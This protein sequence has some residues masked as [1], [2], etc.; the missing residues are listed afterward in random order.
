MIFQLVISTNLS[1]YNVNFSLS[2][3]IFLNS[4]YQQACSIYKLIKAKQKQRKEEAK[5]KL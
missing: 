2:D 3:S 1:K 4:A 5:W